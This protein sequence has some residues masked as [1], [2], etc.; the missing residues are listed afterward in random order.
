MAVKRIRILE[1]SV[2]KMNAMTVKM[3]DRD[4]EW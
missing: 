2:R 1:A 4:T 3:G